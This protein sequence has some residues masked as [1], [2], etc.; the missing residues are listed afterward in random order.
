[1]KKSNEYASAFGRLYAKV[2]KSVFAAVAF[3]YASWAC[4]E[5][6]STSAEAVARFVQEWR[7]LHENG[8]I[9]QKPAS[10]L[11]VPE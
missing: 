1:M 5:E 4:G 3:S 9:P 2:P 6:A 10:G 7:V 11:G 8:I